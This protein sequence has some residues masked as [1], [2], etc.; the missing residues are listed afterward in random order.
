MGVVELPPD[1]EDSTKY[2][3]V[4]DPRNLFVPQA[5]YRGEVVILRLARWLAA[6][7]Q[8]TVLLPEVSA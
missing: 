8:H 6:H 4:E 3:L 7:E 1:D 5:A 2:D